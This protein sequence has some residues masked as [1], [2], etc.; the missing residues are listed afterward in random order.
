MFGLAPSDDSC[1]FHWGP[2]PWHPAEADS[3]GVSSHFFISSVR[4]PAMIMVG[5]CLWLPFNLSTS[6]KTFFEKAHLEV[7]DIKTSICESQGL[8]HDSVHNRR[9]LNFLISYITYH[10]VKQNHGE[11]AEAVGASQEAQETRRPWEF[12]WFLFVCVCGGMVSA[13]IIFFLGFYFMGFFFEIGFV[14]G[15]LF[16]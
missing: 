10:R 13:H 5:C 6:G 15:F 11:P 3:R 9:W 4:I 1:G 16:F 2:I 8:G 14:L 12:T 7:L